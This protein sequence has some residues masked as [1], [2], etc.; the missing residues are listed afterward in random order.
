[1]VKNALTYVMTGDIG[2]SASAEEERFALSVTRFIVATVT[3]R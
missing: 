1:M 3:S 2:Q